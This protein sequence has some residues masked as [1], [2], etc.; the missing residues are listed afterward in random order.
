MNKRFS[1][2]IKNKIKKFNN[3]IYVDGDKSISFRA[4]IISSQCMGVSNLEGIL[5]G[6]D[7]KCCI[8]CLKDLGVK[9][10]KKGSGKFLVFGNGQDSYRQPKKQKLYFGNAGT[11]CILLGFLATSSNINVKIFGDKSLNKRNIQKFIEPLSKIGCTFEPKNKMTLPI[12]VQGTD[13][14]LAQHH[15]VKSGSAQSKAC[16]L[17]ASMNLAGITTIDERILSRN[18]SESILK[19]IGADIR[20]KKKGKHNLIS[21]RGQQNLKSFSLEV[22]GDPSSAAFF[23]ALTLL[24]KGANLTIKNIGLNYYRTGFIRCL[25]SMDANIKI[26]NLRK[27]KFEIIGDIVVK[28]SDLKPI[29]FPKKEVI[30]T[31]DELPIMFIITSQI[32][33]ISTFN[34]IQVLRGKESDRI[35][36]ISENLKAFGIVTRTTKSSLKIWGN[37]KI[38]QQKQI[39][40]SSTLDH[41]IQMSFCILSLITG[42]NVLIKGFETV[43]TSFPS[44]L[45]LLR[46]LKA[47]YEI[48][49]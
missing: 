47:K 42:S 2:L 27:N 22:P 3:T 5:E 17:M 10:I 14:G 25:K 35:K 8:Q 24:T 20:I 44:F 43:S 6:D 36:K 1:V 11:L 21:L 41:R 7:I 37:P 39:K 29:N 48:K 46:E 40:I 16:I 12:L 19:S 23:V 32:Q 30:S 28:S 15:I 49:K 31:L 26:K 9:I 4:L 18:H 13:Y 45:K 34:N 33:G 38:K